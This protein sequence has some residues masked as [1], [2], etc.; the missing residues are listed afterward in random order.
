[1]STTVFVLDKQCRAEGYNRDWERLVPPNYKPIVLSSYG[2]LAPKREDIVIIHLSDFQSPAGDGSPDPVLVERLRSSGCMR[3]LISGGGS[4]KS[5][6]SSDG[7]GYVRATPVNCP[8]D[9]VFT[10][11]LTLFLGCLDEQDPN[12][13]PP[14]ALI[15]PPA[16][17]ENLVSIYLLLM[18]AGRLQDDVSF[19]NFA[20]IYEKSK[21]EYRSAGG[22]DQE[23]LCFQPKDIADLAA[24]PELGSAIRS[25]LRLRM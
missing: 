6:V 5:F 25:V 8:L 7:R 19:L 12:A 4:S 9:P 2:D 21:D 1:M 14:W 23:F 10:D 18:T 24:R 22:S 11:R 15:E 17:P 16:I 20:D 3:L 13:A